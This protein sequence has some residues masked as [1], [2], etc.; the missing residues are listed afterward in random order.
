VG[1]PKG[2]QLVR[3]HGENPIEEKDMS[4]Y[5]DPITET[6]YL[7]MGEYFK[8]DWGTWRVNLDDLTRVV[9]SILADDLEQRAKDYQGATEVFGKR[10]ED[11]LLEAVTGNNP[12]AQG[13]ADRTVGKAIVLEQEAHALR[14][15]V[16]ELREGKR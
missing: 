1:A 9:K 10:A 6:L 8:P 3:T 12:D 4:T 2:L 11:L 5:E 14:H 16:K 13:M 7:R 15:R